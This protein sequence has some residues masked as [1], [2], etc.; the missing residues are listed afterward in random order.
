MFYVL[1]DGI[2]AWVDTREQPHAYVVADCQT[3][4][5]AVVIAAAC[6]GNSQ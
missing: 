1:T 5:A 2:T 6:N 4:A 3:H